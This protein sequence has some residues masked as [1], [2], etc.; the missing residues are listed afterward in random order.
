MNRRNFLKTIGK[1]CAVL[2]F[3]GSSSTVSDSGTSEGQRRAG[4][5]PATEEERNKLLTAIF[6]PPRCEPCYDDCPHQVQCYGHSRW[7]DSLE[8]NVIY[9]YIPLHEYAEKV[10]YDKE[11]Y[12]CFDH[13][14]KLTGFYYKV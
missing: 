3:V 10:P 1:I 7:T 2:P 9:Q 11:L 4:T 5:R 14:G 12:G 8:D 13:R 6:G